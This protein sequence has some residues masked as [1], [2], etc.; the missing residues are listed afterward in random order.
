MLGSWGTLHRAERPRRGIALVCVDDID[1]P[2]GSRA[3]YLVLGHGRDNICPFL[4]Q[5]LPRKRA[6]AL[7]VH[8]VYINDEASPRAGVIGDQDGRFADSTLDQRTDR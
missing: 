3:P 7:P 6:V 1:A 8:I 2:R 4:H 5:Y